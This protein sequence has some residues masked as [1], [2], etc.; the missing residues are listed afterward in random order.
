MEDE[1]RDG[2]FHLL[3]KS[4]LDKD[5]IRHSALRSFGS[6]YGCVRPLLHHRDQIRIGGVNGGIVTKQTRT[7]RRARKGASPAPRDI[8]VYSVVEAAHYLQIPN[9]TLRSWISGR[10]YPLQEDRSGFFPPVIALPNKRRSLLSF[11]NLVEA[12]VLDAIRREH[13]VKLKKVRT[14]IRY[15]KERM[16]VDHPLAY[17]SMVTDGCDLFVERY[18]K[19][20]NVSREGQL[21]MVEVLGAY[22]RRIDWDASG[23]AIRLYPFTR[24]RELEEPRTIVIDPEVSFGKPVLV[25]TGIPTATVAERYKA[26]ESVDDLTNDYDLKRAEIEEAIRAELRAA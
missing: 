14:A 15:M 16:A 11:T 17:K 2:V 22:L 25:G 10:R 23:F 4:P 26:G 21:A 12:H 7:G 24:K 8:P 3:A 6:W 19:L 20:I 18:S 1:G 9:T 13:G 5:F